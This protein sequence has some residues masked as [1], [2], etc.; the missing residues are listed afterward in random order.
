M[1]LLKKTPKLGGWLKRTRLKKDTTEKDTTEKDMAEKDIANN[2]LIVLTKP[3]IPRKG[4]SR[5]MLRFFQVNYNL[6]GL[7]AWWGLWGLVWACRAIFWWGLVIG[8]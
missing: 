2:V 4:L 8:W 6:Y 7:R 5:S 3:K 1:K